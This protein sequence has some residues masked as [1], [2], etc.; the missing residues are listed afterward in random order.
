LPGFAA[1]VLLALL[2]L[3]PA[4]AR[5][6]PVAADSP[7]VCRV[8]VNIE[9]LYDFEPARETFG[10]V[11]WLWSLCPSDDP[12]PM[13][14]IVFRTALPG[15]RA[16]EVHGTEVDGGFYQYRRV[17]GTF[18]HDWDMSRYPFDRQRL[19]IPF[20]ESD[21]GAGVV[22][23]AADESSSLEPELAARL[24]GWELSALDVR[25]SVA[26]EAVD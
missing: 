12:A 16:G 4:A 15:L 5:G 9:D 1:L 2:A 22:I 13:E 24:A 14:T 18:R 17:Q 26:D 6:Q 10:A 21:L 23:F 25:A 19:V 3:A 8:G 20:D 11:L 7:V